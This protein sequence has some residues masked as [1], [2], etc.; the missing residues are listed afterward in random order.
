[1]LSAVTYANRRPGAVKDDRTI[2]VQTVPEG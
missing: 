2:L 1:V